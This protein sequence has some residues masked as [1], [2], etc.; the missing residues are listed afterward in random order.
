MADV[1]SKDDSDKLAL[2]QYRILMPYLVYENTVYWQRANFFL[3]TQTVLLAA[4]LSRFPTV[5]SSDTALLIAH[6]MATVI[7]LCIT[8]FWYQGL[9]MAE[10]WIVRWHD[11]LAYLEPK[12]FGSVSIMRRSTQVPSLKQTAYSA[13]WTFRT[14]WI[15]YGWYIYWLAIRTHKFATPM[16]IVLFQ[17]VSLCL[18]AT[19]PYRNLPPQEPVEV[20]QTTII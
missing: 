12:V 19:R 8:I 1:K 9:R 13:L 6:G 3:V 11:R 7:G 10:W 15:T 17:I 4:L 20:G 14:I 18:F 2:E 16:T 5:G